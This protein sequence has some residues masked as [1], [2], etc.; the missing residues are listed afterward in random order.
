VQSELACNPENKEKR[1]QVFEHGFWSLE[2]MN[3]WP[4]KMGKGAG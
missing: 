1:E 3:L 2:E 4:R